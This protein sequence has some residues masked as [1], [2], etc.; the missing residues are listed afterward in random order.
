MFDR[1]MNYLA[2]SDAW[3]RLY[4]R[5]RADL[6]GLNH[7]E[8]LP[9]MPGVWRD[10]HQR[11]LRGEIV[12]SD[13]EL[14]SQ[15][16]GSRRWLRWTVMP[17]RD[18]KD[19]IGGLII[20]TEDITE[21]K[22]AEATARLLEK[23][24]EL[25]ALK[26]RLFASIG[27]QLRTPL[28]LILG[29]AERM[30]ASSEASEAS[31]SELEVVVRNARTVLRHVNDLLDV[32]RLGA[33]EVHVDYAETDLTSL[34][35]LVASL[36][37]VLAREGKISF[38]IDV[39]D[40]LRAQLDP[41]KLW[42]ILLELLAN[43]FKCT[44]AGERVR[45]RVGVMEDNVAV[46]VADS[47]SGVPPNE[48]DPSF[49]RP[50]HYDGA[51]FRLGGT[52][53]G[54]VITRELVA[55]HG[56]SI[57]VS[58]APEGGALFVVELPRKAP[59]GAEVRSPRT[60]L[61]VEAA[62]R[63]IEDLR[64]RPLAP[65][66]P[67]RAGDGALVL[68]VEDNPDMNH[69]ICEF[70]SSEYRVAAAF[71]GKEGLRKALELEPDLV[72][73]DVVMPGMSGDELL[74]AI[75]SHQRLART[76]VIVSTA[77]ANDEL[78]VQLLREGAEE[79]LT[80]PFS[81]DEL[82]AR[83]ANILAARRALDAQARLASLVEMAPDGIFVVD[84]DSR[85]VEVNEAGCR[86]LGYSRDEIV[87]HE[88]AEFLPPEERDKLAYERTRLFGGMGHVIE[89]HLR[90]KNGTYVPVE[91]NASVLPDGRRQAF[92]RDVSER[93]RSWDALRRAEAMSSGILSASADA[94]ISVDESR[95]VTLFNRAA[96]EL[97]GYSQGEIFGAPLDI[98]VPE[99][100]R[101]AHRRQLALFEEEPGVTRKVGHRRT[102]GLRKNGQEFPADASISKVTV[103]SETIFT[104]AIRDVTEQR[105]I[106]EQHELLDEVGAVLA[107]LEYED[108]LQGVA[109]AAVRALA[110][111]SVLF[112]VEEGG[113]VVRVAAASK[114][115]ANAW[116]ARMM[117]PL[118]ERPRHAHPVWQVIETRSPVLRQLEPELYESIAQSPE[119]LRALRV[120]Q[121]RCALAVPM[122]VSGKCVGVLGWASASRSFDPKDVMLAE[123]VARRCALFIENARLHRA[124]KRAIEA[125]DEVLGIVA[126]DLRNPLSSIVLQAAP[127][128][129]KGSM[130]DSR[131]QKAAG[132]IMRAATR[133]N[134]IVDD[135]LDVTRMEAGQLAIDK[136]RLSATK[137]A[138]DVAEAQHAAITSR[139]LSLEIEV[140]SG[141][142][143]VLADEDRIHQVF[144]NLVGNAIKFTSSGSIS[145][146]AE[147]KEGEVLFW[148]ADK[149]AGIPLEDVP[150][151]FDRF[152]QA[153]KATRSGAGLGLAIVKGIVE[154][155]GGRVWLESRVGLGSTFFFTLPI[156][157]EQE[158]A[159]KAQVLVAEDDP[160]RAG[161]A[162]RVSEEQWIRRGGGEQRS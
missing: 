129:T 147:A 106:E 91:V 1:G 136:A 149:G 109:G 38:T 9:D 93:E 158:A 92:I 21:Q 29:P 52:G 105:R 18:A 90:H 125:R 143:D 35:R 63:A 80:K 76:P 14:W 15:G 144:E 31:R 60:E 49:E 142:P 115:P 39:P 45:L 108:T 126:H 40:G 65:A 110:D 73:T 139:S 122:L 5:G 42:R 53:P 32:A 16:D 47:G 145:I 55:L 112:V 89:W 148:V 94:L 62:R 7:Y 69:F 103:G 84:G 135:L 28:A 44:P 12:K 155:H 104:I 17:W 37:E 61:D 154:A 85:Y 8:L 54:L 97:F 10:V 24:K 11:G 43:A 137:I 133:M 134:R 48:W 116:C 152:W 75:R 117:M 58:T 46:E 3:L 86:M 119:H 19:E 159:A 34:A 83:V 64:P 4:G 70:L 78:R 51:A 95:R 2:T 71:D 41:D 98:L 124:E 66:R 57:T 157:V 22:G 81:M 27:H 6:V 72:L 30:L 141:L 153:R 160:R 123:E 59:D 111:Y 79:Y 96:Q 131:F 130:S 68:V 100:F 120:A 82:M 132:A 121:P 140:Q 74:R 56:G 88:V 101:E 102:V 146:G 25:D 156:A 162:G 113:D 77:V 87:G 36:F 26:D 150:H 161:G 99:R 127:L 20:S 114:E 128:Q 118:S 13:E 50:Q 107:S 23:T 151:L 138:T 33:G 67:A